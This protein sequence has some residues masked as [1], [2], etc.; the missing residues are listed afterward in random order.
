MI[1]RMTDKF[2]Q[3]FHKA[4][5]DVMKSEGLWR[6][7]LRSEL[8]KKGI[9]EVYGDLI[10]FG[11]QHFLS[12]AWRKPGK[13]NSVNLPLYLMF[14]K[15]LKKFLGSQC[16]VFRE[17]SLDWGGTEKRHLKRK[18]MPLVIHVTCFCVVRECVRH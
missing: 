18:P 11:Q 9:W 1:F 7:N 3:Q 15:V 14:T 8:P 12:D 4:L 6:E 13:N 2:C 10:L 16:L 5:I 17:G